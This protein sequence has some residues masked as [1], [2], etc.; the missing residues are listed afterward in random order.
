[1]KLIRLPRRVGVRL[2][3]VP[4]ERRPIV[5]LVYMT[6]VYVDSAEYEWMVGMWEW[7]LS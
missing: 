7:S 1:M 6:P 2:E 4:D 5:T 3:A